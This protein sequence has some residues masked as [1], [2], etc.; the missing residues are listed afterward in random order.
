MI[1][2]FLF[3]ELVATKTTMSRMIS[4]VSNSRIHRNGCSTDEKNPVVVSVLRSGRPYIR[5]Y[6]VTRESVSSN[7]LCD[8]PLRDRVVIVTGIHTTRRDDRRYR[9]L[10]SNTTSRPRS[11]RWTEL[12][13][14]VWTVPPEYTCSGLSDLVRWRVCSQS[15]WSRSWRWRAGLRARPIDA[16]CNWIHLF[17]SVW[18]TGYTKKS[19]PQTHDHNCVKS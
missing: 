7:K 6:D 3:T 5:V 11:Q 4:V 17:I 14:T 10:S 19:G 8:A 13:W 18:S 12:N 2:S 15:V 1:Y 16:W 9:D